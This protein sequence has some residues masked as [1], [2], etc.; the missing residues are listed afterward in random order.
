MITEAIIDATIEGLNDDDS[1]SEV[2]VSIIETHPE[3]VAYLG[4]ESFDILSEVEKDQLWYAI[5]I[6]YASIKEENP[7][8]RKR[9]PEEIEEYEE[10]NYAIIDT[11][12]KYIDM[13]NILFSHTEEEDLLAFVEDFLVPEDGDDISPPG[14]KVM[15]ITLKTLID[16]WCD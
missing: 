13:C 16:V 3:V 7:H 15:F 12:A 6:L 11:Q 2:S 9:T 5:V 10:S 1:F 8:L 14:R 4:S